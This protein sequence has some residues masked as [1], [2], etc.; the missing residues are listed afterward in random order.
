MQLVGLVVEEQQQPAGQ[1]LVKARDQVVALREVE[2][3]LLPNSTARLTIAAK[4]TL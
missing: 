3:R 4:D 2:E 1:R